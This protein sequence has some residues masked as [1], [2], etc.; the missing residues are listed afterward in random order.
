MSTAKV[1][2]AAIAKDEAFYLP[3]W[4]YHHLHVGFD[5]LDIRVNDTSDNTLNV[6]EK[7]KTYYGARLRFSV[8]DE[9]LAECLATDKNF[10]AT[11][12]TQIHQETLQEDFTHLMF[13]DID[14]FWCALDFKQTIKDFIKQQVAFDVTVFQW[15]ME[16]PDQQRRLHDFAFQAIIYGH[17]NSHVKSLMN[18]GANI[19]GVRIHNCLVPDG[20]YLLADKTP[21][22]YASDDTGRG[23]LPDAVYTKENRLKLD[24]YFVYH[25]LF[26]SQGEYLAGLLRGNKQNGDESLLKT[27]RFGYIPLETEDFTLTWQIDETLLRNYFAGYQNLIVNLETELA[28]AKE[29]ILNRKRA[30]L[31]YLKDDIFLQ[32]VYASTMRGISQKVYQAKLV[33]YNIHAVVKDIEFN[34]ATLIC[35]FNCLITS[36]ISLDYQLCI[37]QS[38]TKQLV[39]FELMVLN[40]ACEKNRLVKQVQVKLAM[41]DLTYVVYSKWPTF[42]LVAKLGEDFLILERTKFRKIAPIIA[43]HAVKLRQG[44]H[45]NVDTP[46]IKKASWWQRLFPRA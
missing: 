35:S 10:Q 29:F 37:T 21:V 46:Q 41:Q 15:L 13:L 19:T 8:E 26:R 16:I 2:L 25:K 11:I 31:A 5:V 18:M 9:L 44:R 30:V 42:C 40:E 12:Y 23:I 39:P 17:K 14:E 28:E 34:E 4:V 33:A 45:P 32:H 24:E 3:L 43:K 38:F 6:L 7:L 1:K 20:I 22:H 27:N 36:D